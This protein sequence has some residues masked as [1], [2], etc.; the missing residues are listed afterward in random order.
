MTPY[1]LNTTLADDAPI[2]GRDEGEFVINLI[3]GVAGGNPAE[4]IRVTG[5]PAQGR[6]RRCRVATE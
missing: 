2:V 3:K 1:L 5:A 6:P 4:T